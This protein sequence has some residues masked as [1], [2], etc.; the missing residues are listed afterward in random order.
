MARSASRTSSNVSGRWASDRRRSRCRSRLGR[1]PGPV[2]G[3]LVGQQPADRADELVDLGEELGQ[4]DRPVVAHSGQRSPGRP[5]PFVRRPGVIRRPVGGAAVGELVEERAD[6]VGELVDDGHRPTGRFG[7]R[8]VGEPVPGHGER[9]EH[10][11]QP[12]GPLGQGPVAGGEGAGPVR[13]GPRQRRAD[14]V[15]RRALRQGRTAAADAVGVAGEDAVRRR[16]GRPPRP[17]GRCRWNANASTA[18]P[19]PPASAAA[20]F[21]ERLGRRGVERRRHG[22]ADGGDDADHR[23]ARAEGDEQAGQERPDGD[24]R[25]DGRV[26]DPGDRTEERG[27]GDDRAGDDD[28]PHADPVA[29]LVDGEVGQERPD[30]PPGGGDRVAGGQADDQGERDRRRALDPEPDVDLVAVDPEGGTDQPAGQAGDPHVGKLPIR[31]P[32]NDGP[33]R[34]LRRPCAAGHGRR[35]RPRRA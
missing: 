25:E 5:Q 19:S 30:R 29:R 17:A 22:Q 1:S 18:A 33:P 9:G 11:P 23:R 27:H 20:A 4:R 6:R 15:E 35:R 2:V 16:R 31:G 32:A 28:D 8:A 3:R 24:Q 21:F 14:R 34:P 13:P 10:R 7:R 12:L 26:V